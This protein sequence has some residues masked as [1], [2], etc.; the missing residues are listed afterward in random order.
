MKTEILTNALEKDLTA[1]WERIFPY[2][3][4]AWKSFLEHK[5]RTARRRNDTE[6]ANQIQTLIDKAI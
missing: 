4:M 1:D 3:Q 2:K 5:K 6:L